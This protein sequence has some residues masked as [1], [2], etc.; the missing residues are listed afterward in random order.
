MVVA[1]RFLSAEKDGHG[2]PGD[3]KKPVK[4]PVGGILEVIREWRR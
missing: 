3:W 1:P 2:N 4:A